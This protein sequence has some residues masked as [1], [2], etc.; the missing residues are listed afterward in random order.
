MGENIGLK[1]SHELLLHCV[2]LYSKYFYSF[3]E[4]DKMRQTEASGPKKW[5]VPL[6]ENT[7]TKHHIAGDC[8]KGRNN[9]SLSEDSDNQISLEK[10]KHTEIS[11]PC[12]AKTCW[13][14]SC[15]K[16]KVTSRLILIR[17]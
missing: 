9:L 1:N 3:S 5:A 7:H 4:L 2:L 8:S 16:F 15:L 6:Q 10:E 11:T 12:E 17:K 14:C 13:A